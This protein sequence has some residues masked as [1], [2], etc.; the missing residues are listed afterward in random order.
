M[1]LRTI[2]PAYHISRH[3]P[4]LPSIIFC[5][6][7]DQFCTGV[8]KCKRSR[9]EHGGSPGQEG[10]SSEIDGLGKRQEQEQE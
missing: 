5:F 10:D 9:I 3:S 8:E 7:S 1:L 6:L 4:S 2:H